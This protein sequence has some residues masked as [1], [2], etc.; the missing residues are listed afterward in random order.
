MNKEKVSA[1]SMG[2][3]FPDSLL[4]KLNEYRFTNREGI[5][6]PSQSEVIRQMVSD[7]IARWERERE[8]AA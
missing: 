6:I 3:T 5:R 4:E 2:V 7:G 1:N 8:I